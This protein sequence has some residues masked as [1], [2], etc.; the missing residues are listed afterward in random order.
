[1]NRLL[2]GLVLLSFFCLPAL[3]EDAPKAEIFG[4]YQ[5]LR[6]GS[7]TDGEDAYDSFNYNGF[8]TAVEGNVKPYFGIVGEFGYVRKT[9]DDSYGSYKEKVSS[10]LFGPRFGYRAGK[11]RV[12]GHYLLGATRFAWDETYTEGS[13]SGSDSN[14]SQAIGGGLDI[15]VN[16]TI[17]IRPAQLDLV[18]VRW[19][20][21][22]SSSWE[23]LLRYSAGVV[24]KFGGK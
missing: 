20:E 1:M 19:S 3:A 18:S 4:G 2:A 24:I 6:H 16:K 13:G 7:G 14:F 12:F 8:L 21:G 22:A 23:N 11:V 9:W 17:S 15:A 5:L 10:F